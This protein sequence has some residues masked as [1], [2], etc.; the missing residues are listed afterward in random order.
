MKKVLSKLFATF[1]ACIV[2]LNGATAHAKN[3]SFLTEEEVYEMAVEIGDIYNILPELLTSLAYQ[4][5]RYSPDVKGGK[6]IG[7]MQVHPKWNKERMERL[8]VTDLYDPYGNML[9]AADYLAE[10]IKK[11]QD[12]AP[13]LMEYHGER[14]IQDFLDGKKS[15][16]KYAKEIL[17]RSE[18]MEIKKRKIGKDNGI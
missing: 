16:S 7:L 9:V 13:A 18:E 8:E 15:I 11:Y 10:L 1:C 14:N 5:S 3:I 12:V 6:C 2:L 17:D 4:E